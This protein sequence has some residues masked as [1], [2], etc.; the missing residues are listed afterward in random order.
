MAGRN[1]A[2][3]IR[4]YPRVC[5]RRKYEIINVIKCNKIGMVVFIFDLSIVLYYFFANTNLNLSCS[6]EK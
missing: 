5:I 2:S 6:A 3:D 4:N 1:F